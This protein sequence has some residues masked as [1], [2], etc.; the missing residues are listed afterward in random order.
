MATRAARG[1]DRML[2][3]ATLGEFVFHICLQ[4]YLPTVDLR[5]MR[6]GMEVLLTALIDAHVAT[7]LEN[8]VSVR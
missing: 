2:A 7:M 6:D 1:M 4:N 3:G 5:R 8:Y